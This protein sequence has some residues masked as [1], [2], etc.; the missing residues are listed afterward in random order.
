MGRMPGSASNSPP[1]EKQVSRS[2]PS[3]PRV[4]R[5]PA[6]SP[7]NEPAIDPGSGGDARFQALD[8]RAG[9]PFSDCRRVF[10]A[11]GLQAFCGS[12]KYRRGTDRGSGLCALVYRG[13]HTRHRADPD[14]PPGEP[15]AG[16]AF[17]G[18]AHF[19][20]AFSAKG[21][22]GK[23]C[24][25]G[26]LDENI[27]ERIRTSLGC[28]NDPDGHLHGC[29]DPGEPVVGP[30]GFVPW[31]RKSREAFGWARPPAHRPRFRQPDRA[32]LLRDSGLLSGGL[33]DNGHEA[34]RLGCLAVRKQ[35]GG[36]AA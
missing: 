19:R 13:I 14:G 16:R 18:Q 35:L 8:H 5:G 34:V 21:S 3:D 15:P 22:Q 4:G 31:C 30:D 1:C 6:A 2:R 10:V 29:P 7:R 28:G 12:R 23:A 24:G 32:C 11:Q 20:V 9:L 33:S 17:L 25:G 26:S 36:V 27:R